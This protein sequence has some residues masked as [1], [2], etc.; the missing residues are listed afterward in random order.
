MRQ[1]I[2]YS[3]TSRYPMIQFGVSMKLLR[4]IKM[5]LNKTY[6]KIRIVKYLSDSFSVQNDL[7]LGDAL[8]SLLFKLALEYALRKVQ[9]NQVGLKLNGIHQQIF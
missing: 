2:S 4:L 6:N 5:S 9:E 8:S 1:Y 3:Y 7:N